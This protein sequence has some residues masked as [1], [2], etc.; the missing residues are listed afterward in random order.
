MSYEFPEE[1]R[2]RLEEY[3]AKTMAQVHIPGLSIALVKEGEVVYARG[4]GARN[5]E[6]DIPATPDT[7]YGVGSCTKSFTALA[8]MQLVEQGKLDVQDPVNE[9]LNLKLGFEEDPITIHHLM[10]HSSGVPSLG[11][12]GILISKMTGRPRYWIPMSDTED[13]LSHLNGAQEEVVT[14][15]GGRYF[16]FNSGFTLL[17]EIVERVSGMRY[18][19]YIKE[20]ILKPLKMNR[21]TFLKEEFEK[22]PDIM[23]AYRREDDGTITPTVHPF[24]RLIYAPGGL[25]SSV[26]ECTNY[27]IA[28]IDGGVFN[29][30]RIIEESL[31]EEMHKIQIKTSKNIF[32][33]LGYG[34]G[35]G[36]QENF[37]GHTQIG[38]SGST[39]VSSARL[40]FIPDENIGVALAA[41]SGSSVSTDVPLALLLDKDPDEELPFLK[42]EKRLSMLEGKYEAYKKLNKVS[43]VRRGSLLFLVRGQE[44]IGTPLIPESVTMEDLKFYIYSM[45]SKTLVEFTIGPKGEIDLYLERWWL[46][47]VEA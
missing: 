34:Y 38:H 12:A 31:L 32:G 24:H 5:L 39:G 11:M 33:T 13:F 18:E 16:Y 22:D 14:R 26:I 10:S 40:A 28:N 17:C 41:N 42:V 15:P 30:T 36:I 20:K 9:Y 8:I 46:H 35:W 3:I 2:K 1:A 4:F 27:L 29:G 6:N 44:E 21:S 25:L 37:F 7:L 45:G 19:D 43:V 47:K 23:T